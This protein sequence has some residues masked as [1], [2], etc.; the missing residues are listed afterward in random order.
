MFVCLWIEK[1]K[2]N[3]TRSHQPWTNQYKLNYNNQ[4]KPYQTK[5]IKANQTFSQ[6]NLRITFISSQWHLN[7]EYLKSMLM[8]RTSCTDIY[9]FDAMQQRPAEKL[10]WRVE[11]KNVIYDFF[12]IE[13]SGIVELTDLLDT[14]AITERPNFICGCVLM[15]YYPKSPGWAVCTAAVQ[16]TLHAWRT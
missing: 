1:T 16:F 10:S 7:Q 4:A 15:Y 5:Q 3:S 11:C 12:N 2:L 9:F 8:L 13:F 14:D 6:I